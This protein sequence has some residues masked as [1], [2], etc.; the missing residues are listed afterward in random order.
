MNET[1]FKDQLAGTGMSLQAA[2]EKQLVDL[3]TRERT[4]FKWTTDFNNQNPGELDPMSMFT[5]DR[6]TQHSQEQAEYNRR[7][8]DQARTF[9]Q[10]DQLA[11]LEKFLENQRKMQE[12]ALKMAGKLFG[13]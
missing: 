7:L 3:M 8:L 6:M 11:S 10:Q 4:N 9:L 13:N 5:E 12:S 2:Q 1:Q